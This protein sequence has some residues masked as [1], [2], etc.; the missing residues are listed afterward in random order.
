M[1]LSPSFPHGAPTLAEV[2][3]QRTFAKPPQPF[4]DGEF[5]EALEH[6]DDEPAATVAIRRPNTSGGAADS[7]AHPGPTSTPGDGAVARSSADGPP[8]KSVDVRV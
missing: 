2:L 6:V 1:S 8:A 5:L 7:G 3:L 4:V